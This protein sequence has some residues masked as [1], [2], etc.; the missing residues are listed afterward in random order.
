MQ[1]ENIAL[2]SRVDE[3]NNF[4][5]KRRT[6]DITICILNEGLNHSNM[7][8]NHMKKT[9][10]VLWKFPCKMFNSFFEP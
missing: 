4:I 3:G 7:H 5:I 2:I 10:T 8:S 6:V 1:Q 9:G